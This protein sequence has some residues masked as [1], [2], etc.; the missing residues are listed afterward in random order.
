VTHLI[1]S[2]GL[3]FV[4]VFVAIEGAGI[5]FP[6][7]TALVTGAV[8]AASGHYSIESV[9]AV[10]A[11][12]A[13]AGDNT[14]YWLGRLGGRRLIERIPLL[15]R[16]LGKVLPRAESFFQR[17]G[18]KTVFVAR[19]VAL[20]R[21]TAGWLAGISHMRW[22]VYFAFDAAGSILWA[23]A[24]G[25]VAYEFGRAAADAIGHYGV[26]AAIAIVVLAVIAFLVFRFGIKRRISG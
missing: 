5:P 1:E 6:G 4:F 12:G 17:H 2:Y 22:R 24:V 18:S 15:D 16:T 25:L 14:G 9:I 10:G 21:F 7:E 26:Y 20:L 8:L 19:F 11:A 3:I 13:I 23:I